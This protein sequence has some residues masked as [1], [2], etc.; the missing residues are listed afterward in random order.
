MRTEKVFF[1][2]EQLA[3]T[4]FYY[5][6]FSFPRLFVKYDDDITINSIFKE[7]HLLNN[8]SEEFKAK[9][10]ILQVVQFDS[11]RDSSADENGEIMAMSVGTLVLM[12]DKTDERGK[13][14]LLEFQFNS[15]LGV[16]FLVWINDV[17]DS[18]DGTEYPKFSYRIRVKPLS[19]NDRPREEIIED[20]LYK[21]IKDELFDM[22]KVFEQ[23]VLAG[24]WIETDSETG[25]G[26]ISFYSQRPDDE[27]KGWIQDE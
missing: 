4:L 1:S 27:K 19:D 21:F 6:T 10:D 14:Y 17:H 26:Y 25:P 12:K 8:L 16:T 24:R 15:S 11:Y 2:S 9:R 5:I 20:E 22:I 3:T 23:D 18:V 13:K 7:Q